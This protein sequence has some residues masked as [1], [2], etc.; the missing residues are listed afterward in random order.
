MYCSLR[1]FYFRLL[2]CYYIS[3]QIIE[4]KG[5][6]VGVVEFSTVRKEVKQYQ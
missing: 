4:A 2:E 1:N 6:L 5:C 3:C